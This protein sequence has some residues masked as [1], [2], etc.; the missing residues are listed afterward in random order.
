MLL[1]PQKYW[2]GVKT[3]FFLIINWLSLIYKQ[4]WLYS[5]T[6]TTTGSPFTVCGANRRKNKTAKPSSNW[7][8]TSHHVRESN[9]CIRLCLS[10][11]GGHPLRPSGES[12][13]QS[14][15]S[16]QKQLC[17]QFELQKGLDV[18]FSNFVSVVYLFCTEFL[19]LFLCATVILTMLE[20]W[21]N[22][23]RTVVLCFNLSAFNHF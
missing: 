4:F 7:L 22:N 5:N 14:F 20:E 16:V 8:F 13:I 9:N 21:C 19:S 23:M 6:I 12:L 17:S 3:L 15:E 18:D 2:C 11:R 10:P 1:F